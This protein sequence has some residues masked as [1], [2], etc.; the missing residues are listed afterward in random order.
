MVYMETNALPQ[1]FPNLRVHFSPHSGKSSKQTQRLNAGKE[2]LTFL[3][4]T[5]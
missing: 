2:H 1:L 5:S 4:P 3:H